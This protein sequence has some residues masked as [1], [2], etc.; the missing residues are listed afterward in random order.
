[1]K[2]GLTHSSSKITIIIITIII[3]IIMNFIPIMLK[4]KRLKQ[5][6]QMHIISPLSTIRMQICLN[7]ISSVHVS[8]EL[9]ELMAWA[10]GI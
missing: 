5:F 7:V 9:F 3:T 4:V 1:M 10:A 2:L 6:S 8:A